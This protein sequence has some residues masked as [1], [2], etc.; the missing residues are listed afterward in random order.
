MKYHPNPQDWP[1][2]VFLLAIAEKLNNGLPLDYTLWYVCGD[3]VQH[4]RRA[5][6]PFLVFFQ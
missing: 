2:R 3:L 5:P 1:L 4:Q 6:V